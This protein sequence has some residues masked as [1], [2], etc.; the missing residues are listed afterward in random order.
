MNWIPIISIKNAIQEWEFI[1][2]RLPYGTVMNPGKRF[3]LR[4]PHLLPETRD[5]ITEDPGKGA[6]PLY[7][8]LLQKVQQLGFSVR[9]YRKRTFMTNQ[10]LTQLANWADGSRSLLQEFWKRSLRTQSPD[11]PLTTHLLNHS[12]SLSA[13]RRGNYWVMCQLY[14]L[15]QVESSYPGPGVP[16][17]RAFSCDL[18]PN[19]LYCAEIMCC[20]HGCPWE[21]FFQFCAGVNRYPEAGG[22]RKIITEQPRVTHLPYHVF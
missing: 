9:C 22:R 13:G 15:L 5:A 19:L 1:Q 20:P 16:R 18:L 21:P 17:R 14:K 11:K 12:S 7:I 4:G 2:Q 6:A 3:T 10:Y 8:E